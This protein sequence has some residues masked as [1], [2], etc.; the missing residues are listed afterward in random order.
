MVGERL[1]SMQET[2]ARHS[3]KELEWHNDETLKATE[4]SSF[5]RIGMLYDQPDQIEKEI[6]IIKFARSNRLDQEG[7]GTDP[8]SATIRANY[9][10]DV[11]S[12]ARSLVV[13]KMWI[14]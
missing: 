6:A 10:K 8:E 5:D 13:S 7:I 1:M 9:L 2:L 4:Q 14:S 3:R 12:K 11:E